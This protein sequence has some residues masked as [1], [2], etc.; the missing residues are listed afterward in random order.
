MLKTIK[1]LARIKSLRKILKLLFQLY[2]YIEMKNIT[3]NPI[4]SIQIDLPVAIP[5][6]IIKIIHLIY[7]LVM[8]HV[9][10]LECDLEKC[11][12]KLVLYLCYKNIN[13]NWMTD[14]KIRRSNSIQ[15]YFYLAL[16]MVSNSK[17]SNDNHLINPFLSKI[18]KYV[19]SKTLL[20][21]VHL[22][23]PANLKFIC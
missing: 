7:H 21:K 15:R 19:F 20:H 3:H 14:L 4:D 16:L 9:P 11:K 10:A 12:L 8:G 13:M 18:L 23:V 17:L 2:H 22:C 1:Y 6:E 5:K